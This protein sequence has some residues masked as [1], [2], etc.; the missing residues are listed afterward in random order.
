MGTKFASGCNGE[1]EWN[2]LDCL[3]LVGWG[4]AV[5]MNEGD[6]K[7]LSVSIVA[8]SAASDLGMHGQ[9]NQQQ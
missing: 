3:T 8:L 4:Q 7:L 5:V 1:G 6:I 9:P 2:V